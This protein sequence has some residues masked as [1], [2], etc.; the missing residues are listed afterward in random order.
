MAHGHHLLL[1]GHFMTLVRAS[2]AIS[3]DFGNSQPVL[4]KLY[5]HLADLERLYGREQ[6]FVRF[7]VETRVR[8]LLNC[9][10]LRVIAAFSTFPRDKHRI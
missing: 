10:V 6:V 9:P 5:V 7:L 4:E 8:R 3:V 1:D 2:V